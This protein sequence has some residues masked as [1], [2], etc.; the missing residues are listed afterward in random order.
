MLQNTLKNKFNLLFLI[1]ILSFGKVIAEELSSTVDRN[2][3]GSGETLRLEVK[4][5]G[6]AF[7]DPDFSALQH[8]FE[9]L[10]RQQQ[11]QLS[12]IN[13]KTQSYTTWALELLPK[14]EGKLLI[15]SF[16]YEGQVS[17]AIMIQV[18]KAAKQSQS[19]APVYVETQV[20]KEQ[21]YVQ[22]QL[23]LTR[24]V[25]TRVNLQG[26]TNDDMKIDG[27]SVIKV[28]E[29]QF[30]KNI[31]GVPHL[32]IEV[33]YAVFPQNSGELRIPS[34]RFSTI[35]ADRHDPFG[36]GLFSSGGKRVFLN[37][38]AKTLNVLPRPANSGNG[39]WLPSAGVSLAE[40]WS[41]PLNEWHAGEP[42]TR[43]ITLT[44]Q[45]LTGVQLPPLEFSGSDA[46]KIYPDQPQLDD[47]LSASG[48]IGKRTETMALVP[49]KPGEITLPPVTVSWW[50]T[51]NQRLQKT[52]LEGRTLQILP[53]ATDGSAPVTPEPT[54]STTATPAVSEPTTSVWVVPLAIGNLI[55]LLVVIGLLITRRRPTQQ[56]AAAPDKKRQREAQYFDN[57]QKAAQAGDTPAF[58]EAILRWAQHFWRREDLN[59]LQA[60]AAQAGNGTLQQRFA[61]LDQA[62][63][64]SE[65]SPT[66]DLQE[67]TGLLTNLRKQRNPVGKNKPGKLKSLY[68]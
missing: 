7:G 43:T 45:G 33:K 61:E 29:D 13:G 1:F 21:L 16:N 39:E 35:I 20:D 55:L 62:L 46:V 24:R 41:R 26:I 52:T 8:D 18:N 66:I 23:L 51:K 32:V 63:Y 14:R 54:D 42:L 59:T 38:D 25:V 40:R 50:D 17:D 68:S 15:P 67:I 6:Q 3:V 57:L 11:N 30:Q 37:T 53:A 22:E 28:A 12:I 10:S 58:R 31:N 34:V 19:N 4:W 48:V 44:A 65:A 64:A 5:L 47:Q 60:I 27:A 36:G 56:V 2:Q 9:I 49:S